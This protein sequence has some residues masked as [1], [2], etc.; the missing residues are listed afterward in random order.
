MTPAAKGRT[1]AVEY[2]HVGEA[3]RRLGC[4][5][6]ELLAGVKAGKVPGYGAGATNAWYVKRAWLDAV[7]LERRPRQRALH[8][9]Y[10]AEPSQPE[11]WWAK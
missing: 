4:T 2:V 5:A 10:Q 7:E 1:F 6:A 3:A 8:P 9:A 11:P